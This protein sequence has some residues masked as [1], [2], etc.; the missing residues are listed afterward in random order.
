VVNAT[1]DSITRVLRELLTVRRH[2][3]GKLGMRSRRYAEV[4]HDPALIASHLK[5]TYE[6]LVDQSHSGRSAETTTVRQD[7][8]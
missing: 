3:L 2:E 7:F 8:S 5:S 1:P 6:N 4:W